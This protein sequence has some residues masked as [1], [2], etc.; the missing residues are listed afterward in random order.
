MSVL[1][2]VSHSHYHFIVVFSNCLYIICQL[3]VLSSQFYILLQKLFILFFKVFQFL[4]TVFQLLKNINLH[5]R[6]YIYNQNLYT[7]NYIQYLSERSGF[8]KILEFKLRGFLFKKVSYKAW[9][10]WIQ[11]KW[12][13]TQYIL[14]SKF[15]SL[16]SCEQQ[17]LSL[18][19]NSF[20]MK[21]TY[22]VR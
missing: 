12:I 19:Q 15:P 7:D 16:L 4:L 14:S 1:L 20:T 10:G 5:V 18:L 2:D 13:Y 8:A 9:G 3:S 17:E 11:N 21:L 6:E 22:D